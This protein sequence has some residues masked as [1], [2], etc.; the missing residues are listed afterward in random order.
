MMAALFP[1]NQLGR[2]VY[3]KTLLNLIMS[4]FV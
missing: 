4:V 3:R 1:S 2:K